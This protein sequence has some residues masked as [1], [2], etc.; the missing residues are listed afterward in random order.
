M[1]VCLFLSWLVKMLVLLELHL[2]TTGCCAALFSLE[3]HFW[4]ICCYSHCEY[5]FPK[6]N[7]R[8]C[9]FSICPCHTADKP[10]CL[11]FDANTAETFIAAATKIQMY[12]YKWVFLNV[13]FDLMSWIIS[14]ISKN[15]YIVFLL[16]KKN[17]K[18]NLKQSNLKEEPT[19]CGLWKNKNQ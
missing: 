10:G 12:F 9:G 8:Y 6:M 14:L 7:F 1:F 13:C 4:F 11:Y 3:L 18:Y 17:F 2:H 16:A 5:A 19:N 15:L